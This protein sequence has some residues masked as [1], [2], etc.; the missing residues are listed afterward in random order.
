LY[1]CIL[2]FLVQ[3]LK[4]HCYFIYDVFAI[5]H[6]PLSSAQYFLVL[7]RAVYR[8]WWVNSREPII[9]GNW[10]TRGSDCHSSFSRFALV[11]AVF[12]KLQPPTLALVGKRQEKPTG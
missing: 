7:H 2:I 9:H 3:S 6:V 11:K 10:G 12:D 8:S 4:A 1:F 5:V